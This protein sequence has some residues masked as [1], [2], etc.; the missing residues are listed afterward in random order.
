MLY[1]AFIFSTGKM[2]HEWYLKFNLVRPASS[3]GYIWY[4]ADP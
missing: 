2:Y 4:P 3:C 1:N